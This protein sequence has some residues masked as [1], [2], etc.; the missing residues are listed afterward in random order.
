MHVSRS[1]I[2]AMDERG[3]NRGVHAPREAE[4]HLVLS[5]LRPD[6]LDRLADVV[7]HVPVGAGAADV[8]HEASE[9]RRALL[10]VR[11][12]GVE[13]HA[14]EPARLVGHAGDR[15]SLAGRH[16]LE[17][18]RQLDHLVAVAHP[19]VEQAM[20][21]A[22]NPVLDPL[23]QLRVPPCP[24]LGI[25]E[26]AHLRTLD[27][28]AELLGHRLHAVADPEH[29]DAEVPDRPRRTRR[30]GLVHRGGSAG[31]D[32]PARRELADEAVGDVVGMKL[33]VDVLLA[34]PARDQLRVLRAEV[35]DQDAV[36]GHS[37]R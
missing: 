6:A 26:L 10:C 17:A 36:V 34:H 20:P 5:D 31:E 1:P 14:V 35:E 33:A 24:D 15:T 19:D 23:E 21:L 25:A 2:G 32:D 16:Q 27:L 30:R 28:A 7:G 3:G 8:P 18:G 12:F 29:R 4:D 37:I 11:D 13:L 9:D 22:V